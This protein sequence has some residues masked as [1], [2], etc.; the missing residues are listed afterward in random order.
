M[1]L[2]MDLLAYLPLRVINPSGACDGGS[3]WVAAATPMKPRYTDA[4]CSSQRATAALTNRRRHGR[5]YPG[6]RVRW[7]AL[8]GS[9]ILPAPNQTSLIGWIYR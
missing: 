9:R 5:S 4:G 3:A 6:D 7:A 1:D 8:R 2:L